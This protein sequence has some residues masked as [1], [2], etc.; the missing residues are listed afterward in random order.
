MES[1]QS[2]LRLINTYG[3]RQ[4][5]KHARQGF[6][7]WFIKQAIEGEEIQVFGDGQQVRGFNYVDDVVDALMIAGAND[8]AK[9][10][11]FNLGGE[12]AVALEEFVKLLLKAAGTWL[13][14]HCSIPRRQ[15]GHRRRKRLQLRREIQLRNGLEGDECRSKKDWCAP[16]N[17]TSNIASTI[18]D[19]FA[20]ARRRISSFSINLR[21]VTGGFPRCGKLP[22]SSQ[23]ENSSNRTLRFSMP[24]AERAST[25]ATTAPLAARRLWPRHCRY[26]S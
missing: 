6:V 7:G 15:E 18:G 21:K 1:V 8:K 22:T 3:P 20:H 23:L 24:D 17:T 26:R 11:Y 14:S 19:P 16:S 10:D 12:R 2:S 5:V 4:L 25:S 9:G 13:L